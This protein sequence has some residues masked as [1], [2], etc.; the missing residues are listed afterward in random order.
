MVSVDVKHHVYLLTYPP[1][2][3]LHSPPFY[4]YLI[5][6]MVSVDVKHHVYLQLEAGLTCITIIWGLAEARFP[7]EV[8]DLR[9]VGRPERLGLTHR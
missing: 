8:G 7:P 5:S 3:P 1:P 9:S 6:L 4:P 2:P